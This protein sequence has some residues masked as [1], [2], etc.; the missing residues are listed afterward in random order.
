M[1]FS[2]VYHSLVGDEGFKAALFRDW[3]S[4]EEWIETQ[5]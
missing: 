3:K 2:R 1:A 5:F 4:A